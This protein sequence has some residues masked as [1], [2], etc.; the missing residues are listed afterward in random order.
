MPD[1][2]SDFPVWC[3]LKYPFQRQA[4]IAVA[5]P[6]APGT[7]GV[8]AVTAAVTGKRDQSCP[9]LADTDAAV[10]PV[11]TERPGFR[12]PEGDRAIAWQACRHADN[13]ADCL[14]SPK[15]RLRSTQN[16]DPLDAVRLQGFEPELPGRCRVVGGNAVDEHQR[17]I[18]LGPA[19]P[20]LSLTAKRSDL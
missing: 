10:D 11:G 3:R 1:D 13:A 4:G 8:D 18:G 20:N 17:V 7:K 14:R 9:F 5:V 19:Q 6:F 16:F 2:Q 15:R 12:L